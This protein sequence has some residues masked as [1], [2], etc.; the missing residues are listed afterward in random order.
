MNE[1][2]KPAAVGSAQRG[3]TLMEVL[4]ALT[5]LAI[6]L[7]PAIRALHTG[8]LG[9]EVHADY[10]SNHY[11]LISRLE[12]VLSERY[13]DLEVASA[14]PTV[15]SSYS[16]PSGTPARVLVFIS[17]YD[18]DNADADNDPFSGTDDDV[19]W[20]RAA[21]EDTVQDLATLVTRK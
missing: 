1:G 21:I 15:P 13:V 7:V 20:V 10:S 8:L 3:F 11:R 9:A 14:G 4:V 5:L 17:A 18:I 2:G 12:T 19:L 6:L 16:D